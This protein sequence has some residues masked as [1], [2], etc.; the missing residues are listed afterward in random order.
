MKYTDIYNDDDMARY[1]EQEGSLFF[2]HDTM[3]CF[4]SRI[5]DI[6]RKGTASG[7]LKVVFVTSEKA[8]PTDPTRVYSLRILKEDGRVTSPV[9]FHSSRNLV[10]RL[11]NL[12][13]DQMLV[14]A[15]KLK[16]N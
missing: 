13:Y 4:G 10:K 2:R 3:K 12:P 5:L 8:S 1:A 7:E 6:K 15:A 9:H 14:E 11:L 16:S